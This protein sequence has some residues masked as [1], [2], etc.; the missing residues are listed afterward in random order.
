MK[1]AEIDE[2]KTAEAQ[3]KILR[4]M[5][6]TSGSFYVFTAILLAILA[7]FGFAYYTQL[8]KGLGV[9]GMNEP[10]Y[11]ALYIATFVWFVGLAH[12]GISISAA[13]SVFK[14]ENY[15][16][17]ARMGE[18]L[19]LVTLSLAG[20]MITFDLG[21]P[22]RVINLIRFGRWQSP[23]IWDV[24]I[25]VLYFMGSL[26]FFYLGLR[27]DMPALIK[28]FPRMAGIYKFISQGYRGTEKDHKVN[29]K[30]GYYLGIA[31]LSVMV[32]ASGGVIPLI[33][34]LQAAQ[35][36]WF[37]ALL[38]I[39]FLCAALSSAI[40]CII[41][42]A[43]IS[44]RLFDWY[45][46][47][48]DR[49]FIGLA[50]VLRVFLI[51]YLYFIVCEQL[52]MRYAGLGPEQ[53]VSNAMFFGEFAPFWWTYLLVGTVI[54]FLMLVIPQTRTVK[55]ILI[56]SIIVVPALWLKRMLIVVPPLTRQLIPNP[57]MDPATRSSFITPLTSIGVYTPSWVEWSLLIGAIASG[58]LAFTLFAKF[59][60]LIE[61]D[62]ADVHVVPEPVA[63]VPSVAPGAPPAAAPAGP[64][65]QCGLCD[66]EFASRDECCE[67]A[68]KEH[69]IDKGSCDMACEEK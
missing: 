64:S 43:Y 47:I 52:V 23:L 15:K 11:W 54:P 8:T 12:G 69:A 41:I 5:T 7:W 17:V 39:Y 44:R 58:V 60:P 51:F 27:R 33:F 61:L 2:E 38:P 48:P 32:C 29:T 18:L 45:E 46:F 28:R 14:L 10:V 68:E 53:N 34:C 9:T 66:A 21:R 35:P 1:M 4:T 31:L 67:H 49:I 20:I 22:D 16:P 30:V 63:A 56:A 57:V 55:G 24:F 65:Y 25:I 36:G 37:T 6:Y 59:F 50:N 40:A 26:T 62:V 3:E 19:T 42:I 13:V